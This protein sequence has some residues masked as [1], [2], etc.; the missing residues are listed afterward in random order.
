MPLPRAAH[1]G[2]LRAAFKDHFLRYVKYTLD[3]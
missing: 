3:K 1:A 2:V